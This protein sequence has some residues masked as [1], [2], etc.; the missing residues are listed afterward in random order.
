M[1]IFPKNTEVEKSGNSYLL[2]LKND[3]V[4]VEEPPFFIF[5]VLFQKNLLKNL[6][7]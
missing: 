5:I 4:E 3:S 6:L 2:Q 7:K 1:F